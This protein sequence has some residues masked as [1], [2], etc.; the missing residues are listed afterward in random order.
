MR[1]IHFFLTGLFQGFPVQQ[2]EKWA[3]GGRA[4]YDAN[5]AQWDLDI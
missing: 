3:R 2:G 1:R 4:A 5:E